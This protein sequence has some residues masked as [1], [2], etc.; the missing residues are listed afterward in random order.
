MLPVA[1]A[2]CTVLIALGTRCVRCTIPHMKY[3]L[4]IAVG[5][6]A[7]AQAQP[8]LDVI[9]RGGTVVD[10]TGAPRYLADV[11]ISGGSIAR[12]GNLAGARATT[13]I[14]ATGLYVAPGFINIHS[15]ASAAGLPTAENMLTQGVTTEILN[16]DGRG[17]LD[18]KDQLARLASSGLAVN[19]GAQAGFNSIWASVMGPADRRPTA[20]DIARMRALLTTCLEAGAWGISGGLDYKPA[21]FA[22]TEE[23]VQVLEAAATVAHQL[24]QPRSRDAGIGLQLARGNGRDHRHRG[25]R[26]A[27]GDHHPH[28][29]AGSRAGF[30]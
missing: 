29:G 25:T 2:A 3:A 27:H 23:V 6:L 24:H 28:E 20:D 9:V 15:H 10:G 30:G 13:E 5:A 4:L 16:A 26:R 21:Y 1:P 19:V 7:L 18:I 11:A 8:P 14:D 17:P 22:R 12:I